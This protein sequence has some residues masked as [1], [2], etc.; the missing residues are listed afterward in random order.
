[1]SD[2]VKFSSL[3]R[4][5]QEE[6]TTWLREQVDAGE[7]SATVL[8]GRSAEER[9][10]ARSKQ[11]IQDY[12]R[13]HWNLLLT[14]RVP[15]T[16]DKPVDLVAEVQQDRTVE[17]LRLEVG[18]WRRKYQES[19]RTGN[20]EDS[21]L[22]ILRE[23]Q[24]EYP[25]RL[26]VA[27]LNTE[28][29]RVADI[30]ETIVLL[31]SDLHV[32]EVVQ[33]SAMYGANRYDVSVFL[34]RMEELEKRLIDIAFGALR[35]YRFPELRV[36]ALGDLV[37]GIFGAMHDELLVT[38]RESV[39]EI[40]YGTALVFAQFLARMLQFFERIHVCAAP[41]NHGR[42]YRKPW[43]KEA[44]WNWDVIIPQIASTYFMREPRV[45]WTLPDGFFF[46]DDVRGQRFV[47]LHGHQVKGW[48][49][50]PWYGINKTVENLAT[51][52]D[53]Q[54]TRELITQA[55][56]GQVVDLKDL[57]SLRVNHVVMGHFHTEAIFD[58]TDGEVI[59]NPCMKGGDEF[60]I[61]AGFK[62]A[63]A[64]QT[65]FGVH[66]QHGITHRWRLD[67]QDAYEPTGSL[68]WYGGGSLAEEWRRV[69]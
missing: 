42:M 51:M 47:G 45:T 22:E 11:S 7:T 15:K 57:Q 4:E 26:T 25:K 35:G 36:Y 27:S 59:A 1:M 28:S 3:P 21:V 8:A 61:S 37:N 63:R 60:T 29:P 10:V 50:I 34:A 33:G 16:V 17:A 40:V 64:G 54:R 62:P 44:D 31:L 53:S 32:G 38:Q 2:L 67:L 68:Q 39:K 23:G 56:S 30:E 65:M 43:A 41:G 66:E 55:Q 6:E 12:A 69:S 24:V 13:N 20:R 58:R 14:K 49:S 52:V 18:V 46:L 48:A 5:R 19:I 9:G